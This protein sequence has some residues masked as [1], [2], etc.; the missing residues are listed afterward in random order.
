MALRSGDPRMF[1]V[2]DCG[3]VIPASVSDSNRDDTDERL[4]NRRQSGRLTGSEFFFRGE[5]SCRR[6]SP[7][8]H[9]KQF[10]TA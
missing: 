2:L 1:E 10:P 6:Y 3:P 8:H 9:M 5:T 7:L 4:L